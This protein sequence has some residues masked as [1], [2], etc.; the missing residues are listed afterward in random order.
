MDIS[1]LKNFFQP[2]GQRSHRSLTGE[3]TQGLEN[4]GGGLLSEIRIACP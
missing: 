3:M 4:R 2:A 1:L